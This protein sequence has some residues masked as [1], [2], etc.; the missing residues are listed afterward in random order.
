VH[1]D[2]GCY[3]LVSR[4]FTALNRRLYD[5]TINEKTE[6]KRKREWKSLKGVSN[7][8]LIPTPRIAPSGR[9][10]RFIPDAGMPMRE[11]SML[12]DKFA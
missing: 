3:A 1:D 2:V 11:F 7:V 4:V 12:I 8:A 10:C 9:R 5:Y 6:T